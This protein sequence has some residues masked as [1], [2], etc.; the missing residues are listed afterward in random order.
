MDEGAYSHA[1][2]ALSNELEDKREE[3]EDLLELIGT[4]KFLIQS[5]GHFESAED[6]LGKIGYEIDILILGEDSDDH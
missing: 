3:A 4:I 5:R 1:I 6:V 2:N